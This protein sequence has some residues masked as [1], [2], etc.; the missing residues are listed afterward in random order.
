MF[1]VDGD[2][3]VA[4]DLFR[5]AA[6]FVL[7]V[8]GELITSFWPG[9]TADLAEAI[10]FSAPDDDAPAFRQQRDALP[11]PVSDAHRLLSLVTALRYLRADVHTLALERHGVSAT[12]ARDV[13]RRWLDGEASEMRDAIERDTDR[14]FVRRLGGHDGDLL[15]LLRALPGEDPRPDR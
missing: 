7:H 12:D 3:L 13:E 4:T 1:A 11:Q 10:V 15:A 6:R 2:G 9:A 14:D 5:D 8:Q